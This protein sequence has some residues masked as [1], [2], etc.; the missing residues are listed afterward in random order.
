MPGFGTF[1]VHHTRPSRIIKN[2]ANDLPNSCVE[3]RGMS[4][5]TLQRFRN[6]SCGNFCTLYIYVKYND[7][8][9]KNTRLN[10][11]RAYWKVIQNGRKDTSS[12][13]STTPQPFQPKPIWN[14]ISTANCERYVVSSQLVSVFPSSLPPS[15][16]NKNTFCTLLSF[17][18]FHPLTS[19]LLTEPRSHPTNGLFTLRR[20]TEKKPIKTRLLHT[21]FILISWYRFYIVFFAV[22]FT[23]FQF[24]FF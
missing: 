6:F 17:S 23:H 5:T 21:V 11:T 14:Q 12:F 4:N 7:N 20:P 18:F 1:F 22:S 3:K 8:F 9:M 2:S 16:R 13:V 19:I 24:F 10:S 15:S